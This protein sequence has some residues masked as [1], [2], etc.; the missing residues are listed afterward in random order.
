[1]RTRT[2]TLWLADLTV[3]TIDTTGAGAA[4]ALRL[5]GRDAT[6]Q[7][8]RYAHAAAALATRGVGGQSS[9]GSDPDVRRVVPS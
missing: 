2:S 6:E 9:L 7:A 4:F 3:E 1:V 8:A 5:A